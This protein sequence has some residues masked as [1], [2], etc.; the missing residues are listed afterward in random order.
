M[1]R[2]G[3]CPRRGPARPRTIPAHHRARR[4]SPPAPH[5]A[6]LR[7]AR[8]PTAHGPSMLGGCRVDRRSPSRK[9]GRACASLRREI[10]RQ[11]MGELSSDLLLYLCPSRPRAHVASREWSSEIVLRVFSGAFVVRPER[12]PPREERGTCC[13]SGRQEEGCRR[14]R[15]SA[16]TG[17]SSTCART[18]EVRGSAPT[19]GSAACARWRAAGAPRSAPTAGCAACARWRAAG[20]PRSA[21]TAGSAACAR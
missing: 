13:A 16:R 21:P 1:P 2:E 3:R 4:R 8:R 20:A 5:H 9:R 6:A 15:R 7:R 10:Q 14:R 18:A 11:A 19:A 17:G 12:P